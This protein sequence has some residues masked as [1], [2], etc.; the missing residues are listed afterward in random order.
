MVV[1]V[2][3]FYCDG[4]LFFLDNGKF[5]ASVLLRRRSISPNLFEI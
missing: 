4:D 2:Q 3:A 5:S 1:E